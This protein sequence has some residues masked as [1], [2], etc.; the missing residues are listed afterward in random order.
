MIYIRIHK[1]I[2]HIRKGRFFND[3]FC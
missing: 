3:R 2:E 1:Y